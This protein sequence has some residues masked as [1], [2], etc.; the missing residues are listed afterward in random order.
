LEFII[1]MVFYQPFIALYTINVKPTHDKPDGCVSDA[2]DAAAPAPAS[3][4]SETTPAAAATTAPHGLASS[5]FSSSVR[6]GVGGHGNGFLV[7]EFSIA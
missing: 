7:V 3:P 5:S 1:F 6:G 4:E 2:P